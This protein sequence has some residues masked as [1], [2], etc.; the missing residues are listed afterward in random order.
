MNKTSH[1]DGS[2]AQA[3]LSLIV[4]AILVLTAL[5]YLHTVGLPQKF[6]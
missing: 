5:W 2:K 1:S 4:L 6:P 3:I